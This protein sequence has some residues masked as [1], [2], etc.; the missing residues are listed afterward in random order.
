MIRESHLFQKRAVGFG[1]DHGIIAYMVLRARMENHGKPIGFLGRS[2]MDQFRTAYSYVTSVI[3]RHV[4]IHI[5]FSSER[6]AKTMWTWRLRKDIK[7]RNAPIVRKVI[8]FQA[9]IY[10]SMVE[11]SVS[12]SHA[13]ELPAKQQENVRN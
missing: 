1:L 9:K 11:E 2:R 7:N 4:L 5:I 13:Q 3:R 8:R 6:H 10:D 12:V